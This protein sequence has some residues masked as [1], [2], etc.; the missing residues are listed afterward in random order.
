[1]ASNPISWSKV[2]IAAAIPIILGIALQG[3][4][5]ADLLSIDSL[6]LAKYERARVVFLV[7]LSLVAAGVAIAILLDILGLGPRTLS[8]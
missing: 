3:K 7:D 2:D 6:V 8:P 5:F 4:A 1:M